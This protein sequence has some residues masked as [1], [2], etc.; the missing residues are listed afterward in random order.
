MQDLAQKCRTSKEDVAEYWQR[1]VGFYA[2]R[3]KKA[4][5]WFT[6]S[7]MV[8][9]PLQNICMKYPEA[10]K[11]GGGRVLKHLDIKKSPEVG[12]WRWVKRA[13]DLFLLG[14]TDDHGAEQVARGTPV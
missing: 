9:T 7:W 10:E 13:G 14:T 5:S 11:N 3:A 12:L 6:L 1:V 4:S 2:Q 8:L